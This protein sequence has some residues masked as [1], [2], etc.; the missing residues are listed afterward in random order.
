MKI[1]LWVDK[2]YE[3]RRNKGLKVVSPSEI[4]NIDYDQILIGVMNQK[5]ADCIKKE[6]LELGIVEEKIV[7]LDL[8]AR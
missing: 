3:Q 1:I 7:W 6:L 2:N 4:L 5:V 8:G